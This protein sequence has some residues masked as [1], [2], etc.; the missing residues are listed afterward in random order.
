MEADVKALFNAMDARLAKF[1]KGLDAALAKFAKPEDGE[2]GDGK[3]KEEKDETEPDETEGGGEKVKKAADTDDKMRYA[4]VEAKV[5]VLEQGIASL[6]KQN[7]QLVAKAARD[8]VAQTMKYMR[9]SGIIL[10]DEDAEKKLVDVLVTLSPE[11]RKERY[12]EINQHYA[13]APVA[14]HIDRTELQTE[15]AREDDQPDDQAS[16]E[17]ALTEKAVKFQKKHP[18]MSLMQAMNSVSGLAPLPVGA[19][20]D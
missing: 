2:E 10:G 13:R 12:A 15:W 9:A 6:H 20:S 4:A 19:A 3:K 16:Y 17:A 1:E 18:G 8:D 7:D 5:T 11:D 14:E